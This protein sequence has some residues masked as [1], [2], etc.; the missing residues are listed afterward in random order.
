MKCEE[1]ILSRAATLI[2]A[3][4]EHLEKSNAAL[5]QAF[6]R[7]RRN[8]DSTEKMPRKEKKQKR[9]WTKFVTRQQALAPPSSL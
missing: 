5:L 6:V 7:I 3:T 8:V 2:D 9:F 4:L 1:E